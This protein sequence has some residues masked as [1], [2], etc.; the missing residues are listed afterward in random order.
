[1][2]GFIRPFR[3][4]L[5]M[6]EY[7]RFQSV[8]CGLCHEIEQDYGFLHTLALSYDCTFLALVLMACEP[9]R[10]SLRHRRCIVHPLHKRACAGGS[11]G[12]SHAAAV[13]VILTYHKL[14]DTIADERGFKRLGARILRRLYR[15]GYRRAA[16]RIPDF[17]RTA[18]QCLSELTVLEA[19]QSAS[20]DRP[21][22]TFARLLRASVPEQA[23][24]RRRVLEEMFYHIGRWVYLID[25]CDD[26]KDDFES[27]SYNPIRLRYALKTPE[28]ESVRPQ[29]EHTLLQS[30]SAS[31][32][33]YLLLDPERDSGIMENV[34]CQ[35]LPAVTY[36]VLDGIY[37]N[38][39]G[40]NRHGSI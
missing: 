17:D 35:G 11:E 4:E 26:I 33:A 32:H 1:M 21:A 22:D 16:Q 12:L 34:L 19:E 10:G 20:L 24:A 3:D 7:D 9:D 28:L 15:R 38:N 18:Q 5:K 6:R 29:L 14:S 37:H 23:G 31:Y 8:Y 30:L 39:G 36:Q 2:F 27:G 13:S 40:K 25:A